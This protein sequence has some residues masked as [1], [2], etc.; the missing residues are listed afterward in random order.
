MYRSIIIICIYVVHTKVIIIILKTIRN[1]ILTRILNTSLTLYF[2]QLFVNYLVLFSHSR[3]IF[4]YK[5]YKYN[6]QNKQNSNYPNNLFLI[7]L[8]LILIII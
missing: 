5:K 6:K 3:L 8:F 7:K 2:F 4:P 1:I